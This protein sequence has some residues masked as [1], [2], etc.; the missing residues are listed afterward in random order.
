MLFEINHHH[1]K[2][3]S[4]SNYHIFV[5]QK[6]EKFLIDYVEYESSENSL[7][8]ITP[9]QNLEWLTENNQERKQICFHGDYYC[10]EY[11]KKEVACNGLLFNNIY[12]LPYVPLNQETF[13]EIEYIINK[14]SVEMSSKNPF[15]ETVIKTYLQLILAISSKEKSDKIEQ[16]LL[17]KTQDNEILDFQNVL[18]KHF[19]KE[20]KTS[21]YADYYHLTP[22][23]FSKRIKQQFGKTPSQLIQERTILEAKKLLHLTQKSIK[24]IAFELNFEDEYYFSKYFKKSVDISPSHFRKEVGISIVAK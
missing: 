15:S 24:E 22:S 17:H 19:I 14:I 11:H 16:S 21:F 1:Q 7:L 18:E 6:S 8:F 9:Y 10:I 13:K 5:L 2:Y 4:S 12:L 20:K 3:L 23:V